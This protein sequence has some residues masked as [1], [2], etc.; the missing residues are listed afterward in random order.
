[1][2]LAQHSGATVRLA[3]LTAEITH[4]GSIQFLIWEGHRSS[5][6]SATHASLASAS[7]T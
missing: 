3:P 6:W 7:A 5:T 4:R 1:M 2:R